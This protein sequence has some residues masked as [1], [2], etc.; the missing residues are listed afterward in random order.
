MLCLR[1]EAF[2]QAR[3]VAYNRDETAQAVWSF[4]GLAGGSGRR[5]LLPLAGS[6]GMGGGGGP[7]NRCLLAIPPAEGVLNDSD[8]P[9]IGPEQI[10]AVLRFLPV[11]ETPGYRF[12]EWVVREGHMPW[13]QTR[14][15]VNAFVKVL[16]AHDFVV[17]F[18]WMSWQEQAQT[19]QDDPGA[20]A[21]AD[22][23]T[24]RKLLTLH[25]RQDRLVEGHLASVLEGGHVAAILR[26]LKRIREVLRG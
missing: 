13:Y 3:R 2:V 24:I 12:G 1:G 6:G 8:I 25:V 16:Y 7:L 10:D 14:A 5:A 20:L 22:L 21:Q 23:L 19:Y 18:D 26:R 4:G 15:E 17:R 9:D 11:F